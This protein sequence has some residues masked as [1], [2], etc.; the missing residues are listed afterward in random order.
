MIKK[1]M[2]LFLSVLCLTSCANINGIKV[3]NPDTLTAAVLYANGSKTAQ[4]AYDTLKKST[5]AALTAD[6][7]DMSKRAN[8]SRYDILY[9]DKSIANMPS[10][11]PKTIQSY[12]SDGGGSVVLD[13]ELYTVFDSDFIGAAEFRP[14]GGCPIYMDYPTADR[15]IKKLQGILADLSRQYRNLDDF[16]FLSRKS[17]GV[18]VVPSTAQCI[19]LMDRMG[20]Y[21]VNEYG[22]GYVF[23]TNPLFPGG[24]DNYQSLIDFSGLLRDYFAEY[25]SVKKYGYSVEIIPGSFA[26]PAAAWKYIDNIDDSTMSIFEKMCKPYGQTPSFTKPENIPSEEHSGKKLSC[27]LSDGGRFIL[28]AHGAYSC[29]IDINGDGIM[30]IISGNADGNLYYSQGSGTGIDYSLNAP[31]VLNGTDGNPVSVGTH[32]APTA[33]DIDMDGIA[34]II[35][36]GADGRI[37][38]FAVTDDMSLEDL[39]VILNTGLTN[40]MPSAGDLNGDGVTDIAAGSVDGEL[41]VYYGVPGQSGAEYNDY[42]V[43]EN[44]MPWYAPCI[45]DFNGDGINELYAGTADGYIVCYDSDFLYNGY[46]EDDNYNS[47]GNMHMKFG[48]NCAPV[49]YDVNH[50]GALDIIAVSLKSDSK[51]VNS[52]S[53]I[54]TNARYSLP[55]LFYNDYDM[56]YNDRE[57]VENEIKS[58]NEIV[59]DYKYIFA[60]ESQLDKMTAAADN[61]HVDAVWENNGLS[62]S[63]SVKEKDIPLYNEKY[64]KAVGVKVTF[65]EGVAVDEFNVDASVYYKKDNCIYVSLDK[66]AHISKTGEN[67]D[68]NITSVNLPAK[69][70]KDKNGAKIRFLDGG[71]M[72]VS[73]KGQTKTTSKGWD[74]SY[75]DGITVFRKYGNAE[76]IEIVR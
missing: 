50:D 35:C 56:I 60:E 54:K 44:G 29:P 72:T 76:T 52:A 62:L 18:G 75:Q 24:A 67:N 32:S 58:V 55:L 57:S 37:H 6:M 19:S 13:N 74:T 66:G 28:D 31:V 41:R 43:V 25:V 1:L 11:D 68:I 49:F 14:L 2:P 71:L 45:G 30:D 36:G 8:L 70:K 3:E 73:V 20:I 51:P 42:I 27:V 61:T 39:G 38:C 7:I 26:S 65:A 22:K 40:T 5:A 34:E 59:N 23:F 21:T 10:F 63:A 64:Q 4:N 33:A 12:V 16:D 17:Y 9:I 48:E 15:D 46:I 47:S 53:V 69:I